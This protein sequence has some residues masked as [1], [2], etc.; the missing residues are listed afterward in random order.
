MVDEAKLDGI[1]SV[2]ASHWPERIGPGDLMRPEL[3]EQI[4][5]A[6]LALLGALD[7]AELA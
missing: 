3:W 1:A 2:I 4:E 5:Q 7:L 6:R